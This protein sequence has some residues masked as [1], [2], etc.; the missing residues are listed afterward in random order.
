MTQACVFAVDD[1]YITA[2]QVFYHSLEATKSLPADLPLYILHS[3]SLSHNSCKRVRS[4]LSN[5]RRKV[6][7]LNASS[8]LP[9][10]LPIK[11]SDY[12]SDA[13]FYR[14]F[15]AEVIPRDID[16]IVYLDCDMLAV[17]NA[18]ALFNTSVQGLVAA[19][20]H[21][22]P[23]DSMRLWGDA[24]GEYFQA[25]A[26]I[27]PTAKWIEQELLQHFLS[28]MKHECQR[29]QW[30]DQDV[31]NITLQS[32]WDRL[33]VWLNT[34]RIVRSQFP[35]SLVR[36]KARLIHFDGSIKPWNTFIRS[37][38]HEAWRATYKEVFGVQFDIN[39]IRPPLAKR[40]SRLIRNHASGL[41]HGRWSQ[42][43]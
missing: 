22:S 2:F 42:P 6:E 18:S 12:V 16:K 21:C 34:C 15:V 25:G 9:S 27:I 41:I 23:A 43:Y 5:Y 1:G 20:D 35:I 39:K 8:L 17:G 11:P 40:V 13:T 38:W 36:E 37:P 28:V 31:L 33:S 7:F 32:K 26:L 19:A 29:I 30:W 10:Y 24:C 4:F 14:L 3:D